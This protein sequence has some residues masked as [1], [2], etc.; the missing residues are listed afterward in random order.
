MKQLHEVGRALNQFYITLVLQ[1]VVFILL[2]L[3]ILLY[4][5]LLTVLAAT[6][7]VLV[8]IIILILA[9]K[10]RAFIDNLPKFLK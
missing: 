8:G 9:W 7:F 1:A 2:G 6:A 4:P 3:L 5:P 10:I